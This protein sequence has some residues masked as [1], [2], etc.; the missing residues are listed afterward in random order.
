M[1]PPPHSNGLDPFDRAAARNHVRCFVAQ[2]QLNT[3]KVFLYF[4]EL[5]YQTLQGRA[6]L[7][8]QHFTRALIQCRFVVAHVVGIDSG[9]III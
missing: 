3:T 9:I 6:A 5:P 1:G 2:L 4:L 7:K 8:V